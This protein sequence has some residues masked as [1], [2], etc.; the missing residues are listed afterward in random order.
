MPKLPRTRITRNPHADQVDEVPEQ[1]CVSALLG[2][3]Q[4]LVLMLG[5]RHEAVELIEEHRMRQYDPSVQRQPLFGVGDAT[6][7]LPLGAWASLALSRR[8]SWATLVPHRLER[9]VADDVCVVVDGDVSRQR[10]HARH[11]CRRERHE[12]LW[13]RLRVGGEKLE[14]ALQ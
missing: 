2:M 8:S 6:V 7:V 9:G 13:T 3:R 5:G 10:A 14:E 12:D 1:F 11:E 4:G